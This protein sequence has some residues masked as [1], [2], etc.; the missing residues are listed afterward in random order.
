[1][2]DFDRKLP[3]MEFADEKQLQECIEEY[4]KILFLQDWIIQGALV[5]S[6][7]SD[8]ENNECAGTINLVFSNQSALIRVVKPDE[9]T[10]NGTYKFCAEKTVI[11]ELLHCKYNWLSKDSTSHEAAYYDVKEHQLLEQ[12]AK[13]LL[14]ARYHLPFKWF[15]NF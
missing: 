2:L 8:G 11:H 1:M 9:D 15:R 3:I 5:K 7:L 10:F 12:M 6:P 14:L 4:Q 13:S